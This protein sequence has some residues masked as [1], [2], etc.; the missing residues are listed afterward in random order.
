MAQIPYS[1]Q[2]QIDVR[3]GTYEADIARLAEQS[4]VS[5]AG[6]RAAV[7]DGRAFAFG[8]QAC[9]DFLTAAAD[10]L[11]TWVAPSYGE[12]ARRRVAADNVG[13]AFQYGVVR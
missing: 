9:V 12:W 3:P 6:Y 13:R 7:A 5:A 1:F 8:G 2:G 10:D 4:A 11:E